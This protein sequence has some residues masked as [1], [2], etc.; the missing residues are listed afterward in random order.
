MGGEEGN[1]EGIGRGGRETVKGQRVDGRCY[2][3]G[4]GG[5]GGNKSDRRWVRRE[6][7]ETG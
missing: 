5:Q 2:T 4:G 6:W 3:E 1:R 7:L